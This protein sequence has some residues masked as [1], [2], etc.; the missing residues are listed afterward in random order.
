M[1]KAAE[2]TWS[3]PQLHETQRLVL[4]DVLV[5]G[6]RSRAE[7][8]RRTGLSR[9]SLMRLTRDLVDFGL[10]TEG[11]TPPT[12]GRGRPSET[13]NLRPE[14]AHFAG[15]KLTGDFLYAAVTDL[16]STVLATTERELTSRTV[17]DVVALI[18]EVIEGFTE[19]YPRLTSMGVCLAGDV[20]Q[21]DDRAIVVGS[22]FLGW[23]QVPLQSLL[24]TAT[25][26]PVAISNDVQALTLAHHWFGAGVGCRSLVVIG[27]GAG[28]GSGI[29]VNDEPILGAHGHPGKIGHILVA[30]DG[31][32]CDSGHTG[33]ASSFVTIPA[34]LRNAGTRDF[35]ETL[36]S[37][38]TGNQDSLHALNLAGYA[39]GAVIAE[40]QNLI[41]PDKV[42]VTGEGLEVARVASVE[43]ERGIAARLDPASSAVALEVRDFHFADYAW[44]AAI[45]AIR[46]LI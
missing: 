10:V 40:L 21:V 41:D 18:A 43:V 16:H 8:T 12:S 17:D 31:P 33:C 22:H 11:Q 34:I 36:Q 9:A 44:A 26:L 29:V 7:L 19:E 20:V 46:Q 14:S 6:S 4:Q 32:S 42:V 24:E 23:D 5:H 38:A 2:R 15:V 45:S 28:I 39:L 37:A 13:L 35:A 30:A 25:G 27:L 1:D 3:W